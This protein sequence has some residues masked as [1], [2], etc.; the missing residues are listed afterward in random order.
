VQCSQK[1]QRHRTIRTIRTGTTSTTGTTA[2]ATTVPN[3]TTVVS[4]KVPIAKERPLMLLAMTTPP[5]VHRPCN[6]RHE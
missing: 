6:K 2:A 4:P 3:I 5:P 1:Q